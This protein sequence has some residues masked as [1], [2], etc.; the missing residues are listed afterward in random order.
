[1]RFMH[2]YAKKCE[3]KAKV[4]YIAADDKKCGMSAIFGKKCGIA[5]AALK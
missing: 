2:K 3:I 1:M 4:R 5:L